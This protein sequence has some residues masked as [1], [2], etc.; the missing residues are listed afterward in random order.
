MKLIAG[1]VGVLV[2]IASPA[3]AGDTWG[4]A[5]LS[6]RLSAKPQVA[7]PGQMLTYQVEVRNA[8][9]GDAVLPVLTIRL[10][11]DVEVLS[12]DVAECAPGRGM[13]EVVCRSP[14]DVAA[15][16]VGTVTITGIVRPGARGPLQA[17]ASLASEVVD[18]H[19]GD[20]MARATT[21]VDDGA[22]L[23]VRLRPSTQRARPG[24][25]FTVAAK[26]RN[27]GPHVVKDPIVF[28]QPGRAHFV[29]ASGGRCRQRDRFVGCE[30]RPIRS[31]GTGEMRLAFRVPPRT[32]T[33]VRARATVYSRSIGDRNPANNIAR[34]RLASPRDLD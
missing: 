29:S 4:G 11:H 15:G 14:R 17:Q 8:G 18:G 3:Y 28:F 27:A 19:D 23:G 5:D 21:A 12:V 20:N 1:L 16:G 22:D 2:A 31:G 34:F 26:V 10:P 33:G 32:H 7:Q 25:R 9:P 13:G 6:V 30:M 24:E